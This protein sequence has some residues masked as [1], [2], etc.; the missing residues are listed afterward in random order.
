MSSAFDLLGVPAH[1]DVAL[2][3]R[4][5]ARLLRTTRP[6]EDAQA[7]QRLHAAYQQALMQA[8]AREAAS[9]GD[10]TATS[11]GAEHALVVHAAEPVTEPAARQPVAGDAVRT[12]APASTEIPPAGNPGELASRIIQQA[13]GSIDERALAR[14]LSAQPELWSIRIKQQTGQILLQQL[15]RTPA[16]MPPVFL[17]ALL[18]FF[19]LHQV[20][21]GV[22]PVA[23]AQLRQRQLSMWYVRPE[24]HRTCAR[25]LNIPTGQAP[26]DR[27]VRSCLQLLGRPWHWYGVPWPAIRRGRVVTIAR[28]I[29]GLCGGRLGDLPPPIDQRHAVFWYRAAQ[30]AQP[31]WARFMVGSSRALFLGLALVLCVT[32]LCALTS[33]LDRTDMVWS[34]ALGTGAAIAAGSISIWLLYAA[35]TWLDHWQGLPESV[36]TRHPW[37]RRTLIPLLCMLGMAADY[38]LQSPL[39]ATL[40]IIPTLALTWRRFAH[41]LPP[42]PVKRRSL[43]RGVSV[44]GA[45]FL[46]LFLTKAAA[47]ALPPA[48]LDRFP[49]IAIIASG[50]LC[51]WLADMW[52]QR[53][54]LKGRPAS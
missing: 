12:P 31:S 19:D 4:A 46:L 14:W 41:R 48:F 36:A 18:E 30:L 44:T 27:V 3:K 38:L 32:S 15:F 45:G 11:P 29:H 6:D 2:V 35:W 8:K 17:D 43:N 24:N 28:L 13:V 7:F 16:P 47:E 1:A 39:A 54:H 10:A 42:R 20:Q 52:R 40:I 53:A 37:F 49:L 23:L 21:S 51:L 25:R 5:Y 26:D 34:V 22:N 9:T 33:A 50:T